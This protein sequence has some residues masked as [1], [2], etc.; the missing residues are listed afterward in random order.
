MSDTPFV[1]DVTIQHGDS[2]GRAP[3]SL[4]VLAKNAEGCIGRLLE[5]IGPYVSE[6]VVVLNDTMD[7]SERV[8]RDYAVKAKIPFKIIIVTA[9]SHPEFYILDT[10]ETYAQG[11]PLADENF[12]GPFTERPILARWDAV[13]NLGWKECKQPWKLF[14]DADD[15]VLDPHCLPGLVNIL[16]EQGV[17]VACSNYFYQVDDEGRPMSASYRERLAKNTPS[18]FWIFPIHECLGGQSRTAHLQGSL[19]VRDMRDNTGFGVRI[20]GRNFKILYQLAREAD[21]EVPARILVN[22]IM[23]VRGMVNQSPELL[24]FADAL[25]NLYLAKSQWPEERGWALAMVGEMYENSGLEDNAGLFKAIELY[26]ESLHEHPGSKVAFR[27]VRAQFGVRNW[28][29][30]LDAFEIGVENKA[31]H[32]ILDSGALYEDMSKILVASA[33]YELEDYDTASK[34]IKEAIAVFPKNIALQ[35]LAEGMEK[36]RALANANRVKTE[37]ALH[38][39]GGKE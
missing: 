20:P 31:V 25:L 4:F 30:V 6:I 5:N 36:R 38:G 22:L 7:D 16:E 29:G 17:E 35:T 19:L 13:R 32:Q 23:E 3:V 11:R 9:A 26:K 21:W 34:F 2:L 8:I 37:I 33:A 15:V 14:L 18:I 24:C 1:R 12:D 10:R 27:M 39:L 28:R